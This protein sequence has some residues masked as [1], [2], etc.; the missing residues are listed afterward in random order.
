MGSENLNISNNNMNSFIGNPIYDNKNLNRKYI[1]FIKENVS[2]DIPDILLDKKYKKKKVLKKI[3]IKSGLNILNNKITFYFSDLLKEL[4][5]LYT[6]KTYSKIV[7]VD[8][9]KLGQEGLELF[10]DKLRS[11]IK[12]ILT[13]ENDKI[14]YALNDETKE[15]V[16][17]ILSGKQDNL[18]MTN[19][20]SELKLIFETDG[21]FKLQILK[22]GNEKDSGAFFK[23]RTNFKLP[24]LEKFGI[25]DKFNYKNYNDNCFIEAL[26]HSELV[27]EDKLNSIKQYVKCSHLPMCKIKH[28]AEK[29]DLYITIKRLKDVKNK[30]KYGDKKNP[31]IHIGLIDEHY[32]IIQKTKI[33]RYAL[34]NYEKLKDKKEWYKFYR[35]GKRSETCGLDSYQLIK[36]LYEKKENFLKEITNESNILNTPYYNK[37]GEINAVELNNNEVKEIKYIDKYESY[38]DKKIIKIYFDIETDVYGDYHKPYLC[39]CVSD[40]YKKEFVGVDCCLKMMKFLY[41]KYVDVKNIEIQLIAHNANYDFRAGLF[42]HLFNVKTI[43]RGTNIIYATADFYNFTKKKISIVVKD[44]YAMITSS[45]KNFGSLFPNIN[46]EKE[47]MPY[48]LYTTKNIKDRF[49]DLNECLKFVSKKNKNEYVENCKKW[50]CLINNKVDIIKYSSEYCYRD[51]LTLKEGYETFQKQILFVCGLNIE[52]YITIASISDNYLIKEGCYNNCYSIGGLCRQF[53][54][55]CLVGGRT[56]LSNNKKFKSK[57][58]KKVADYDAVSLYPSAMARLMGF[59]QGIPKLLKKEQLNKEFLKS[60]DG[61]YIRIKVNNIKHKLNFPLLSYVNKEGVRIFTNDMVDRIIYIDNTSLEDCVKFQGLEYEII[62][63]YYFNDGF[64]KKIVEC[65]KFLFNERIKLKKLK[66]PLQNIYKLLMNSGY[67]KTCLKEID[68]DIK[69]ISLKNRD[70]FIKKYYNWIKELKLCENGLSYRVEMKKSVSTHFNRVHIGIQILSMSK[71]IMNEVMVKAENNNIKLFY[72]DTDS[73]HLYEEDVSKLESL[74]KKEYGTELNGKNMGQF[75]IDFEL[76]GCKNVYSKKF[77]GLAKKCYLDELEGEN[78]NG[79]LVNDYHIRMKG[80]PNGCILSRCKELDITPIE[81]YENLYN[82]ETYT[83]DLLKTLNND[84]EIVSRCS[85]ENKKNMT[86]SSRKEYLVSIKF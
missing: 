16:F 2:V 17:N 85:F 70:D 27:D 31:E 73:I 49:I 28:I 69:Y 46:Q 43:E 55:N 59:L 76:D 42:K 36:L 68:S 8:I 10:S 25:Y 48:D 38:K 23:Y 72:Q 24:G 67:G 79:E 37:L 63:G 5:N 80:V 11:G 14:I 1:K 52:H 84:G 7:N 81:L 66:N 30:M 9:N 47:I 82:G 50:N 74:F 12:F 29:Y 65:I 20:D 34:N 40:K 54:Q 21:K 44:S 13:D 32:F 19:S 26:K 45:L 3:Y 62:D 61:Y 41:K 56:M 78:E 64:N 33:T 86:I 53:I 83:F 18:D 39:W 75:H 4:N 77:I 6:D 22:P 60:V 35:E 15:K 58:N 71:R 57:N 51:C